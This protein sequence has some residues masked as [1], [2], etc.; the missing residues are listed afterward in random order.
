MTFPVDTSY[1][2]ILKEFF[3]ESKITS[4]CTHTYGLY[5]TLPKMM[6]NGY[7]YLFPEWTMK[8]YVLSAQVLK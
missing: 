6:G 3:K 5:C 8:T 2:D 7:H 4:T 1:G